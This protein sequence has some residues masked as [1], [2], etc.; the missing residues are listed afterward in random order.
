MGRFSMKNCEMTGAWPL[1]PG[2][3]EDV[4]GLVLQC[5]AGNRVADSKK[6]RGIICTMAESQ[7]YSFESF[8]WSSSI[9]F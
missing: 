6:I 4:R 8:T 5:G 2:G 9:Y 7:V 3:S 1:G